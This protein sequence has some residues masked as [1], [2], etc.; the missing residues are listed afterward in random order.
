MID[1]AKL[2]AAAERAKAAVADYQSG[3]IDAAEFHRLTD[4]PEQT[5]ELIAQTEALVAAH[6]NL[7]FWPTRIARQIVSW[8]RLA[9]ENIAALDEARARIAELE[10][11]KIT[12]KL[13]R[14]SFFD[15]REGSPYQSG[16][17][18]NLEELVNECKRAG[19]NIE[20]GGE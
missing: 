1:T 12:L 4:S 3:V 20:T 6:V 5:L 16:A 13:P 15:F 17:Y 18:C 8:R 2:K 14:Y 9:K 19:I 11:R 7:S 10:A